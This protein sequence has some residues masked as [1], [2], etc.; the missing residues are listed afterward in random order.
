MDFIYSAFLSLFSSVIFKNEKRSEIGKL[1]TF[2]ECFDSYFDLSINFKVYL[3]YLNK[4]IDTDV[5]E[6]KKN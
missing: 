3:I 2:Y 6:M 5:E 1:I 4:Q